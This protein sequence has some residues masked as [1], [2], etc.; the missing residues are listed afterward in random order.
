MVGEMAAGDLAV[1]SRQIETPANIREILKNHPDNE[2]RSSNSEK[3]R[4]IQLSAMIDA[5]PEAFPENGDICLRASPQEILEKLAI[6]SHS[7]LAEY[8]AW[9]LSEPFELWAKKLPDYPRPK[10]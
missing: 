6:S 9:C 7:L 8:A 5:F 2:V 1:L 3:S 4:T 10:G